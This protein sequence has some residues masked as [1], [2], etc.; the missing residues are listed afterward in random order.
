MPDGFV[1]RIVVEPQWVPSEQDM[2]R[3]RVTD[4][5]R[6]VGKRTGREFA[7]YHALWRWSVE[8]LSGFWG[9]VWEYFGLGDGPRRCWGVPK[10]PARNGFRGRG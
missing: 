2:A 10:C 9:G 7:D 3:A 6:F 1:E 4:F 5:A 8:D